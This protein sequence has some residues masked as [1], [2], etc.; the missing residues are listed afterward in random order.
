MKKIGIFGGTFDPVHNQHV[1]LA[2][3]AIEILGLDKLIIMPTYLPPHKSVLPTNSADRLNMLHLAF[4]NQSKIE[5]SDYEISK[6]GTSYTYLTIEHFKSL[7]DAELY[8]IVGEDMLINFKHWKFPEKILKHARLAVFGRDGVAGNVQKER[9]YFKENFNAD[10]IWLNFS[11]LDVSSSK[12]RVYSSFGLDIVNMVPDSV[13]KYIEEN[14]LYTADGYTEFAKKTLTEKRLIHT[15]NV[16]LTALKKAKEL[17]LDENKV[18]IAST[19][20][21]CAKYL[22]AEDFYGF[23]VPNDMPKAVVHAYLGAYVCQ[24][25]LKI[26][27]DEIIDA[28]RYHTTGKPNMS[29]LS[30][31]VFVA[32]MIEEG[33]SYLGVDELRQYFN[34]DF[35]TCFRKCL[36]EEVIH[37]KNR[38]GDIYHQTLDAYKYYIEDNN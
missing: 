1:S 21:D 7:Y 28:V 4:K 34:G 26:D 37:L 5:V 27:D 18:R 13:R 32:D 6:G 35:E 9:Q 8:F 36:Y 22:K 14:H 29:T 33:R 10:F 2:K 15:A 38:G 17:G 31:L 24:T 12:I 19:L 3:K 25:V 20:H 23:S 30:K 11:G 16:V